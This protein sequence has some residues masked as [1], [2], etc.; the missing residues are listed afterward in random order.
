MNSFPRLET[1]A[2]V[3]YVAD[4]A[5]LGIHR[6]GYNGIA[7]LIP[8]HSGNNL[9]VPTFAGLNYETISLTGL[10][11]YKHPRGSKFEPRCEPMHIESATDGNVVLVQPE[12]SHA[13]VSSRIV[14]SVEEPCYLHQRIELTFHQRFCPAGEA[15]AFSSLWASYIHMPTDRH[16]YLKPDLD[17]GS[18]LEGWVGI[19]KADH[20]AD[21]E[22][23]RLPD[24]NEIGPAEHLAAMS[25]QRS[26]KTTDVMDAGRGASGVQG[27][28]HSVHGPLAFYYGFCHADQ[29]FLMMFRQPG[30]FRLAYSPCGAGK[31]PAW[32]PAW[33]Y[34]LH[35]DDAQT[36]IVYSWDVCLAIKPY[37]GRKN[38]LHELRR[39]LADPQPCD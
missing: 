29:M 27:A 33:D 23:R 34:V 18:D 5:A 10:P 21:T 13:H 22:V 32:N 39:Y 36:G 20:S 8:K 1:D 25:Q 2:F 35:L 28:P 4:N 37:A 15:N 38:V 26:V 3:A 9:F 17:D 12:T 14:F 6:A 11:P 30:R 7:S 24:T 16:I 19:T 31:E